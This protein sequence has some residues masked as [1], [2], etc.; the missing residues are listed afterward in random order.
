MT[1][2]EF[3]RREKLIPKQDRSQ[4]QDTP[5]P[6]SIAI[7]IDLG[8]TNSVVSVFSMEYE[9]PVTLDYEGSHLVPSLV[10]YDRNLQKT[11]VGNQAKS[12]LEKSPQDVIK[13]TKKYMGQTSVS[14]QSNGKDYSPEQIAI[15]ILEYLMQHPVLQEERK[16][17]GHI[18]A[19]I[20]VPA[21]FDDAA[22]SATLAAAESAGIYVLRI[23]NEPTAAALAYSMISSSSTEAKQQETLAVFDF[24]GGTFDVTIV[25][26]Q[27]L[28]FQVLSSEGDIHLGGDDVDTALCQFL[29]KKVTP[30]FAA[31]KADKNS[32]LY[33]KV[34]LHAEAVK[35]GLQEEGAIH[36]VDSHLDH[37]GSCLDTEITREQFE[38]MIRPIVEKSLFLTENAISAARREVK[39]ISRILLVG[40]SSKLNLARKMLEDYFHRPVDASLEPDLAIS[41][42]ACL[43]SAIILG[44]SIDTILVDV[45]SHTLGVV[46]VDPTDKGV[47]KTAP[48]LHRNTSLPATKSEFF[49]TVD[50]H[51]Q[52]INIIV[53][54]GESEL[55]NENRLIGSFLFQLQPPCPKGTKCEIQLTY[56]VNGMVHIYAKQVQTQNEAKADFDSRTGEVKGW[57][58]ISPAHL[59]P[60]EEN[61]KIVAQ[62]EEKTTIP[63]IN[64][65]IIRAKKHLKSLDAQSLEHKKISDLTKQYSQLLS[66]AQNGVQNDH[67]LE[68]MEDQLLNSL[69]KK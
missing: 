13:S 44:I 26:R 47:L 56:D 32:E 40:G 39:N 67:E 21:H 54:Q 57:S 15:L 8:T 51:Q 42:G 2:L 65:I 60:A 30:P 43:Q 28:S 16:K 48:I 55:A 3:K 5:P 24:G 17:A 4:V 34:L 45:C 49:T 68:K 33:R 12:Y 25:E 11:W 66:D 14:F 36:L 58:K 27:E 20:T 46:V 59:Q 31:R 35:K 38:D 37:Q 9:R 1:I 63:V 50:D 23:I 22:R 7:G 69:E 61:L 52:A 64:S 6:N 62:G 19:V 29:L 53:V 18:W 41:W 10:Y